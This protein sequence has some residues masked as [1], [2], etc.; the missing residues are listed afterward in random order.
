M[1]Q[2]PLVVERDPVNVCPSS[3]AEKQTCGLYVVITERGSAS[4]FEKNLRLLTE[5]IVLL[6]W[7]MVEN[8]ITAASPLY[9]LS[10]QV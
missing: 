1:K 2:F 5:L 6:F 8:P 9:T 7:F 3:G 10:V 4:P